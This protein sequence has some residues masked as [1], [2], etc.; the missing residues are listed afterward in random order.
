M[1]DAIARI[2]NLAELRGRNVEWAISAVKD[3]ANITSQQALDL[4]VIDLIEPD[5]TTLLAD[6][7]GRT[8][9]TEAGQVT[10]NT[11]NARVDEIDLGLIERFLQLLAEPTLAYLLVSFGLLALYIEL[12]NP[13]LGVPGIFGGIALLLGLLGLG[14]LPVAWVGLGLMVLAFALFIADL[15]VPSLGMLTIGGL[16]SFVIGSNILIAEGSPRDLQ[17]PQPIVYTMTACLAVAAALLGMAVVR[18]QF[19]RTQTGKAGMIGQVGVARTQLAPDGMVLVFGEIWTATAVD[20]PIEE[21]ENIAVTSVNGLALTVRRATAEEVVA[22][23]DTGDRR[24]V[25]PVR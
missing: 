4:G 3:A 9:T 12:S 10:L 25:I 18:V 7:N 5:L 19:R 24:A 14:S 6:I 2:T 11:A 17:V 8:V 15:F 1:N 16:V 23:I 20:S 13:G 21:G 22:S